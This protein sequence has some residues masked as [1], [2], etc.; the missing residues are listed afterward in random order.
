VIH[1]IEAHADADQYGGHGQGIE[2]GGQER[3]DEAE[4]ERQ[5]DLGA[6]FQEDAGEHEQQQFLHEVDARHHEHEQQN[7]LEVRLGLVKHRMRIGHAEH[8]RLDRQQAARL[9]G[10]AAQGQGQREDEFGD[11][12]PAGGEGADRKQQNGVDHQ[13]G[14]NGFLVPVRG[15]SQEVVPDAQCKGLTPL[16]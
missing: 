3:G 2:K 15:R 13:E 16:R 7:H 14:D 5:Q 10:I 6:D 1:G 9:Q 12:H 8:H 4:Q 11:Q